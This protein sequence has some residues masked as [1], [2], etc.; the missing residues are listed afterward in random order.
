ME[1]PNASSY[2]EWEKEGRDSIW[3]SHG[4][5]PD[6]RVLTEVRPLTVEFAERIWQWIFPTKADVLPKV[7]KEK[8]GWLQ[9]VFRNEPIF[10]GGT[11]SPPLEKALRRHFEWTEHDT[12]YFLTRCG[13]GY[14]THW[15]VFLKNCESFL[16]WYDEGLLFH[17]TAREVAVFW[18]SSAM[19]IGR[20]S[21]R[22]L[23]LVG[24]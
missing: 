7:A 1:A 17:P 4:R 15:A 13:T 21:K 20:R 5:N 18:E 12:V 23:N 19:Y 24:I 11:H 2:R 10:F 9:E 6:Q 22:R 14:E 8:R 16:G 3:F